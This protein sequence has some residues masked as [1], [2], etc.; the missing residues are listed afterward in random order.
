MFLLFKLH[1]EIRLG[2][3]AGGDDYPLFGSPG[4]HFMPYGDRVGPR[5]QTANAIRAI[6][7]SH[8][9]EWM[10]ED[11]KAR[12]HPGMHVAFDAEIFGLRHGSYWAAGVHVVLAEIE[13]LVELRQSMDVVKEWVAVF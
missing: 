13:F 3:F 12:V 10:I 4:F 8:C 2:R 6:V 5:R 9:K 11:D 7:A 1:A